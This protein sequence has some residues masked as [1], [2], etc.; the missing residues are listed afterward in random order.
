MD[1]TDSRPRP[2][3][4]ASE[5]GG[6]PARAGLRLSALRGAYPP[7]SAPPRRGRSRHH[8][9]HVRADGRPAH[10]HPTLL[11]LRERLACRRPHRKMHWSLFAS[12]TW[13]II[14]K[15]RWARTMLLVK[16][17]LH[18]SPIAGIGVFA[19]EPIPE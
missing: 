2:W 11:G 3:L 6:A 16:T 18:P 7:A 13:P 14:K 17:T 15:K 1:E 4:R 5:S 19:A 8:H 10:R 9:P 12:F